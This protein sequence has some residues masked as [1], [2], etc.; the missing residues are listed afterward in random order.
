MM[1]QRAHYW[2]QILFLWYHFFLYLFYDNATIGGS[3]KLKP[4]V[5]DIW[6]QGFFGE[7][8]FH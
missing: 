6:K 3:C 8:V 1:S 5:N 2:D 7:G 4:D